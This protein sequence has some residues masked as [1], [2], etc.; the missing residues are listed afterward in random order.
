MDI[1]SS[2]QTLYGNTGN[3]DIQGSEFRKFKFLENLYGK[4]GEL[5]RRFKLFRS[6]TL[7]SVTICTHATLAFLNIRGWPAMLSQ[8]VT[9]KI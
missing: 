2:L 7:I 1:Y 8:L 3:M 5:F 4:V 6:F 9:L